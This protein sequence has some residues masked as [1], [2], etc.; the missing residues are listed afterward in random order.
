MNERVF[1]VAVKIEGQPRPGSLGVRPIVIYA[2]EIEG[3]APLYF[4]IEAVDE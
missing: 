2:V 3:D 1:E 4:S